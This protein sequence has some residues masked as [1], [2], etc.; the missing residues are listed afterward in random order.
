V[1]SVRLSILNRSYPW[2]WK[3]INSYDV[4]ALNT[5]LSSGVF[6]AFDFELGMT[7]NSLEEREM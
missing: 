6:L 1:F 2:H 3:Q 7:V 5:Q 4:I